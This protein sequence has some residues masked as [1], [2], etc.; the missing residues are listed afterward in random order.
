MPRVSE[1]TKLNYRTRSFT[2]TLNYYDEY[3][4]LEMEKM[5]E[6]TLPTYYIWGIEGS[7][8]CECHHP[9]IHLFVHF[10]CQ[11]WASSIMSYFTKKH[12]H[13]AVKSISDMI[14]YCKGYE[15]GKLKCDRENEWFEDGIVPSNGKNVTSEKVIIA[16]KEGKTLKELYDIFPSYM[17][18]HAQKVKDYMNAIRDTEECKFYVIKPIS[19]A[20]TEIH[21]NFH[22][23]DKPA[24]VTDLKQLEAYS[25]YTDVVFYAEYFDR[26]Y[27]LW[28]RGV[29]I[30][31]Q[32]GYKCNVVK[33]KR[34]IIVT[35]TPRLYP[36]YKNIC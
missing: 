24:I 4:L 13:E 28:P 20:I 17:I 6:E 7:P 36:L 33:C 8:Y 12:H 25:E 18:H 29:P 11:R 26:L 3:D 31:Y 2:L 35:D 23:L 32:C 10:K 21:D 34:F 19:D 5:L 1:S 16:I 9:H 27:N 15:K 22:I 14:A 30:T